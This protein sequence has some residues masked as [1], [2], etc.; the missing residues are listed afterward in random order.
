MRPGCGFAGKKSAIPPAPGTAA[1]RSDARLLRTILAGVFVLSDGLNINGSELVAGIGGVI[2]SRIPLTGGL[3]GDGA[4]FKETLVGGDCEPRPHTV[5]AIGFYG[6]SIRVGH[7][8]AG[9]WD[10]FGPPPPG[11]AFGR[12]RSVRARRR[13]G[14]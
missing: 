5:A 13:T 9:G 8:S 11:D 4:D 3:A 7:G 1:R 6:P 14:T 12:Q 2:G 10:L